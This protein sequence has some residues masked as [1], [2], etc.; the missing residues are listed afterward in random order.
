MFQSTGLRGQVPEQIWCTENGDLGILIEIGLAGERIPEL[1]L[2]N[3][4]FLSD[5]GAS[6]ASP[7]HG[8]IAFENEWASSSC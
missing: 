7:A 2:G 6:R 1:F 3:V 8:S 4:A 5:L